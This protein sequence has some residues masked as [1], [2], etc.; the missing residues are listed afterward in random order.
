M[1]FS[2]IKTDL[3]DIT[4]ILLESGIKHNKSKSLYA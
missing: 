2:T 4:E 3:Y 1:V